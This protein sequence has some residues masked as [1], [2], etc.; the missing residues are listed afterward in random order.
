MCGSNNFESVLLLIHNDFDLQC[1]VKT[2]KTLQKM[3]AGAALIGFTG[4]AQALPVTMTDTRLF[5]QVLNASQPFTFSHANPFDTTE[6][7]FVS[8]TLTLTLSGQGSNAYSVSF[9]WGEPLSFASATAIAPGVALTLSAPDLAAAWDDLFTFKVT[10][11]GTTGNPRITQ[12]L[13]TVT[14]QSVF[15]EVLEVGDGTTTGPLDVNIA[16]VPEPGT[17]ALLG[18]GLLGGVLVRR[19][20]A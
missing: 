1:K 11:V 6:F 2:M 8:A 14:A 13:L 5:N 19:R 10:V 20:N 4:L 17:L 16:A 3:L 15:Q 7:D 12:S 9:G 18:L